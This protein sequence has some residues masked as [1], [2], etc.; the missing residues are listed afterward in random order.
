M[1]RPEGGKG[2]LCLRSMEAGGFGAEGRGGE[3]EEGGA[4]L[5]KQQQEPP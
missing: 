4:D 5:A 3:G 2:L 1:R